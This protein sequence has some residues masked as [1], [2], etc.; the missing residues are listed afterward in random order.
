MKILQNDLKY[1]NQL[2]FSPKIIILF[3]L[4]TKV[5]MML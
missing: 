3:G 1:K 2:L 5:V 4:R